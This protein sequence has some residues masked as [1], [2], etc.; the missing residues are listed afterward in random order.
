[1]AASPP[2]EAAP[3]PAPAAAAAPEPPPA[4]AAPAPA[5]APAAA[6]PAAAGPAASPAEGPASLCVRITR[7]GAKD[8]QSLLE[9]IGNLG[10][11][12]HSEQGADTLNVW[13]ETTCSPDDIEAVCC[14]IIDGDQIA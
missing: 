9:E 14:F 7:V 2:G 5:A 3:A 13:V 1:Q 6:A 10:R 12:L 4:A 11:I 8:A